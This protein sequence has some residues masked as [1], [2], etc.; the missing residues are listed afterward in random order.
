MKVIVAWS[1]GKDSQASLIW[2]VNYYGKEK[3]EAVFCDTGW[4]NPI[5][6]L[7]V[8]DVC[9]LM[10]VKLTVIRNKKY[11][12]FVD[13]AKKKKRFPS[14]KARFCTE[15][16][17]TEPMI[18]Y[19]LQQESCII[20]QGIRNDESEARSKMSKICSYFRFY[21]EPYTD[22]VMKIRAARKALK[23]AKNKK[24]KN[25]IQTKIIKL[26]GRLQKGKLDEKYH[27]Y[28]KKD[29]FEWKYIHQERVFRPII[30]WD[31]NQV[32]RKIFDAGQRPNQLYYMGRSRVGCDP[33]VMCRHSEV[34][35]AVRFTPDTITRLKE[36]EKEV[37]RS[38]FPPGFI[39]DRYCSQVDKNGTRYPTVDDVIIYLTGGDY[40][41][42]LFADLEKTTHK[43]MSFYGICE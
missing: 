12:G 36:A 7:H 15:K 38:F 34:K 1:G 21:Y 24:D 27:N 20:I 2:A 37:E 31:A 13:L 43:C 19:I 9:K 25:K 28:R 11:K 4:E 40:Q 3:V 42:D 41:P 29:V 22:N 30:K 32:M 39:P 23:K 6:Y 33:C 14:T 26:K 5:T 16:L 10:N 17:K 18:D 35:A 8:V